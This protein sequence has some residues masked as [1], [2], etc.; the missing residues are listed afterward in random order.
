MT[1][2]KW[3]GSSINIWCQKY[4]ACCVKERPIC[5]G[6]WECQWDAGGRVY[7]KSP[8]DISNQTDLLKCQVQWHSWPLPNRKAQYLFYK[9]KICSFLQCLLSTFSLHRGNGQLM[10]PNT[11]GLWAKKLSF[12]FYYPYIFKL[13]A[14]RHTSLPRMFRS[15]AVKRLNS[16]T[17]HK[18]SRGSNPVQFWNCIQLVKDN[19]LWIVFL[20]KHPV[21]LK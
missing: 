17:L 10:S 18:K 13:L 7:Y 1:Q 19:F 16:S 15:P 11:S 12:M 20:Q 3:S 4:G 8:A 9:K 2:V 14:W 21:I 6:A 5:R